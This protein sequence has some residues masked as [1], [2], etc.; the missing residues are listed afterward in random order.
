MR[1]NVTPR[2]RCAR[3]PLV[4][5]RHCHVTCLCVAFFHVIMCISFCIRV[6]LMHPS[7]F[8]IVRFAIRHSY[9][10]RRLPFCLSLG[11]GVKLSRKGPRFAKRPW[12]ST[13]RPP[14]MFRV[15]WSLFDTLTVNRGTVK[16][17]CVLQPNTPSKWPN[18][19]IQT[20]SILS[21]VRS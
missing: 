9:V 21:A 3:C 14:V 18:K 17:S 16:A 8:P 10:L 7:I 20:P 13:G 15:I 2:I 1:T 5:R 11:A 19:P 4:I 6:R 12:Y